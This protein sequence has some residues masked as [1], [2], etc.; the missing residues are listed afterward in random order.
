ML[1]KLKLDIEDILKQLRYNMM[2]KIGIGGISINC[3][4]LENKYYDYIR[5]NND[6][7]DVQI[8]ELQKIKQNL[9]NYL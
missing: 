5:N 1:E 4:E 7:E 9:E 2:T 8:Q 6:S 3:I